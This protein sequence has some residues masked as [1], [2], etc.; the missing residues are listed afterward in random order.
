MDALILNFDAQTIAPDYLNGDPVSPDAFNPGREYFDGCT[1]GFAVRGDL[2]DPKGK[3]G[4]EGSFV[5]TVKWFQA[6]L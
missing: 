5:A 4:K 6:H 3:A 1:H 2:S